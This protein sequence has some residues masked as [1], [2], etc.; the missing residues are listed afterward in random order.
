MCVKRFLLSSFVFTCAFFF[1]ITYVNANENKNGI[2]KEN[3][4]T[5]YYLNSELVKNA[6]IDNNDDGKNDYYFGNDGK[7]VDGVQL[8]DDVYYYFVN[9]IKQYGATDGTYYY[10]KKSGTRQKNYFWDQDSD[11]IIDYYFDKSGKMLKNGW[12]DV[13][14]DSKN[15]Y[16]FGNDGKAVNGVQ[17]IDGIYYYFV[18]K[19]VQYGTTD[20]TYYYGKKSGTRQKNYFWDKNTDGKYDYYFGDDYKAVDGVQ[21]IDN[22]EYY[23]VNKIIQYGVFR[24]TNEGTFYYGKKS[25]TKQYSWIYNNG[26]T[27]YFDLESGAMVTGEQEID[28]KPYVF[29]NNG[30][31]KD[32]WQMINGKQYY[33]YADGT[34]A[35]YIQKIAGKRYEFSKDGELQHSDI[36]IIIDVSAHQ[37]N[38]DW[39]TLWASGEIDGV[40]LRIAA[41][42][43]KEDLQLSNYINN[44][45]R[46]GIPYGLY[47]YSYAENYDE[48]VFYGN[49]TNNVIS[50]YNLSPT[51]GIYFDL[52]SN[53]ITSYLGVSQY[54]NIVKGYMNVLP[55]AKVYTYLNYANTALNSSYIWSYITWIAQY[56][57]DCTYTGSYNGWQYTS[58]GTMPGINGDVDVSIFYK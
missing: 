20:G 23:F 42:A 58:K 56:A 44:V 27:Y 52:E 50:K 4:F 36:K 6:W 34:R 15:D 14:N 12:I 39:D 10:G 29:D 37:G 40:I 1:S 35:K 11:G 43:E 7:A 5:Y 19:K 13:N 48:G 53:G 26:K 17:L 51:L 55:S 25:G 49:F 3:G 32:G 31:L 54:E 22:K 41:G 47:I 57:S 24:K 28:G 30:A 33:F 9:N 16:Y 21:T 46:L 45:K 38:I 2:V 18:N 8:I